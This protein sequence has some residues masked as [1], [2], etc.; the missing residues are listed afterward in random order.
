MAFSSFWIM[1]YLVVPDINNFE[2]KNLSEIKFLVL[3]NIFI[4][5]FLEF[6]FLTRKEPFNSHKPHVIKKIKSQ[7]IFYVLLVFSLP[8][9]LIET[10]N[11]FSYGLDNLNEMYWQSR[12]GGNAWKMMLGYAFAYVPFIYLFR[13]KNVDKK[14]ILLFII[15]IFIVL[16]TGA[17]MVLAEIFLMY[18]YYK[19][20]SGAH[21]KSKELFIKLLSLFVLIIL[22]VTFLRMIGSTTQDVKNNTYTEIVEFLALGFDM[23]Q[24]F[25]RIIEFLNGSSY[26]YGN[27]LLIDSAYYFMPHV[28]FPNKPLSSEASRVLYPDAAITGVG[29]NY[30]II[31]LEYLNFG[32]FGAM[33]LP[34]LYFFFIRKNYQKLINKSRESF[35]YTSSFEDFWALYICSKTFLL[36]RLGVL[37]YSLSLI[38]MQTL[39]FYIIF[40]LINSL[41]QKRK[42]YQHL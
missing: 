25:D 10:L 20:Q 18:I 3:I 8:V 27:T 34:S 39:F 24:Q 17:R 4:I 29:Y 1:V 31:P 30:G 14:F 13:V 21:N 7:K 12:R 26:L 22:A 42:V 9:L 41:S 19:I 28:L 5:S 32:F 36:L 16:L 2:Y 33:L 15:S 6:Y 23:S 11:L 40:R 38:F 37:T 35:F